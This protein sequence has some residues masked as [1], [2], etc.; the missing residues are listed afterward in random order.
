MKTRETYPSD[1][2][3]EEWVFVAPYL[4]LIRQDTPQRVRDL[5]EIFDASR[6]LVRAGAP[7]R[8]RTT[9]LLGRFLGRP[10]GGMNGSRLEP[11]NRHVAFPDTRQ[12]LAAEFA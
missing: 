3:D 8:C 6:W 10:R 12:L 11:R 2:S 9:S 1:A 5:R 7:R 4:A